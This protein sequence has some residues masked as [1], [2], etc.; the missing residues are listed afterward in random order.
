MKTKQTERPRQKMLAAQPEPLEA[1]TAGPYKVKQHT[2]GGIVGA[3]KETHAAQLL[4]TFG[5]ADL[6]C[7]Q[8]MI[9]Q[10]MAIIPGDKLPGCEADLINALTPL[11]AG[12]GPRDELEGMLA[13]QMISVHFAAMDMTG[14]AMGPGQ[15]REGIN[16]YINLATKLSRTFVAQME[17]LNKHRGRGGQRVVVEYINAEK[18]SQVAVGNFCSKEGGGERKK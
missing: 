15:T 7:V 16:N 5:T 3:D 14:R 6:A 11:L 8:G 4:A 17:S 1:H 2:A 10:L 12:I 9:N 18:G 13:C